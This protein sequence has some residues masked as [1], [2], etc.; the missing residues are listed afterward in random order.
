MSK[1]TSTTKSC[2]SKEKSKMLRVV[3]VYSLKLT[4]LMTENKN[5]IMKSN[6]L[7][8]KNNLCRISLMRF[9]RNFKRRILPLMVWRKI[10]I[11][12]RKSSLRRRRRTPKNGNNGNKQRRRNS[13]KLNRKLKNLTNKMTSFGLISTYKKRLTGNKN[14]TLTG[15]NGKWR[16]KMVK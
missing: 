6:Y 2:Y 8:D 13:M 7:R 4:V 1:K 9:K 3:I 10:S 12:I 5:L 14:I 16:S 11:V 15:S